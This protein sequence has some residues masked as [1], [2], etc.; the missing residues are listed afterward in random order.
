MVLGIPQTTPASTVPTPRL[1]RIHLAV[2]VLQDRLGLLPLLGLEYG[3][4][5]EN[6]DPLI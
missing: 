4:S 1:C 3:R 2:A 6:H 5:W